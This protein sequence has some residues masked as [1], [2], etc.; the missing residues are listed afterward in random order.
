MSDDLVGILGDLVS[1]EEDAD[2]ARD[3]VHGRLSADAGA[4]PEIAEV[5]L[6]A[7]YFLEMLT[8]QDRREDL[9]KMRLVYT[10]NRSDR[11]DRQLVQADL[12]F[13]EAVPSLT[14]VYPSADWFE[15][16]VFD[17]YGVRFDGHPDL[18]RILCPDDADF[19][20]LLKDFGRA[21]PEEEAG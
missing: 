13:G 14:G 6:A 3:G 19:H 1:Q 21:D 9:D 12:P 10:Y 18:K 8:C 20:P 11:A 5:F 2:Y 15:R 4:L 17:M 16:E 7:G